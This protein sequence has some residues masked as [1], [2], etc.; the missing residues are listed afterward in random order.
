[1]VQQQALGRTD[2][3]EGTPIRHGQGQ[4]WRLRGS[5][6]AVGEVAHLQRGGLWARD[7]PP[8]HV[9]SYSVEQD[10]VELWGLTPATPSVLK[11]QLW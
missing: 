11:Q 6:Q 4:L 2:Q 8:G 5:C 3:A 7:R 9:G 1:M 10:A